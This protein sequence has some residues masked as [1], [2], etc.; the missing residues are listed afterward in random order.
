[1]ETG[2]ILFINIWL[3]LSAQPKKISHYKQYGPTNWQPIT[4]QQFQKDIMAIVDYFTAYGLQ[5]G[6]QICLVLPNSYEWDVIEKACFFLG[7][8]LVSIDPGQ[9]NLLVKNALVLNSKVMIIKD[10]FPIAATGTHVPILINL[11][12]L[13]ILTPVKVDLEN[14]KFN[15]DLSFDD[16]IA[17]TLFTCDLAGEIKAWCYNQQQIKDSVDLLANIFAA[18]IHQERVLV[19]LPAS[20][21]FKIIFNL[22]AFNLES[23]LYY[24]ENPD[25]MIK[26][27]RIIK[28]TILIAMPFFFEKLKA[29]LQERLESLMPYKLLPHK[30]VRYKLMSDGLSEFL[31]THL[32]LY[33]LGGQVK[34]CISAAA[35]IQAETLLYLQKHNL[36]ILEAYTLSES[37]L[38]IAIN[39]PEN[40]KLGSLGKPI[41]LKSLKFSTRGEIFLSSKFLAKTHS[42]DQDYWL[43]TNDFG[44]LDNDGYLFL[45]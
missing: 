10:E 4:Q 11:Y 21:P 16:L 25:S 14:I 40:I 22:I 24:Q 32:T 28:P 8:N 43:K 35:A 41:E 6:D 19:W 30:L 29:K 5:I 27:I 7:L 26:S 42:N 15:A 9:K 39:T 45:H 36:K 20:N 13:P 34:F 31:D 38:P 17:Y 33:L 18:H 23:V 12:Q 1:M 2:S 3:K 37:I 44:S